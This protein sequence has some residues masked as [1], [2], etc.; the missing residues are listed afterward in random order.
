MAFGLGMK[1][2]VVLDREITA[3]LGRSPHSGWFVRPGRVQLCLPQP[4]DLT[5]DAA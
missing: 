3:L 4:V 2:F 5:L 1:D